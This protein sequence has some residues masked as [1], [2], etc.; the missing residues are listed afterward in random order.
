[1]IT[2]CVC[3]WVGTEAG[4]RRAAGC[5]LC[6][7]IRLMWRELPKERE[8]DKAACRGGKPQYLGLSPPVTSIIPEADVA[9]MF[10]AAQG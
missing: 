5:G 4:G 1:M 6:E 7:G 2:T 3:R 9:A 10:R 8:G